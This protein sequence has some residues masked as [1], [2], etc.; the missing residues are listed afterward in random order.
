MLVALMLWPVLSGAMA[1]TVTVF[2]AASLKSALDEIATDYEAVTEDKIVLVYAGSSVLARQIGAGAPADLFISANS[3]WMDILEQRGRIVAKTRRDVISNTLVL[4]APAGRGNPDAKLSESLS[5]GRV[6]MALVDAVPAGI[7]G[8]AALTSLGLWES[9]RPRI[10]QAD[11]VRAAL[12]YVA[13]G[14]VETGIVYGSD[15][16]AEPRVEV[17]GTFP[18]SSH[19][20]IRYPAA[21]VAGHDS[22]L[23]RKFLDYVSAP[24]QQALFLRHGFAVLGE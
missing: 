16:R 6:A 21:I 18:A 3:D 8:R 23:T 4:V 19:P 10:V 9:V 2:A 1:G 20:P 11:N 12:A 17:L 13:Q 14:E 5:R 24:D 22:A 15:A 7:Y